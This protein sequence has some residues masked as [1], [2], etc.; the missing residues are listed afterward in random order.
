VFD[1]FKYVTQLFKE[2]N[3]ILKPGGVL[4]INTCT[5]DQLSAVWYNN[6]MPEACE[7]LKARTPEIDVL[8]ELIEQTGFTNFAFTKDNEPLQGENY[9]RYELCFTENYRAGDAIWSLVGDEEYG[10]AMMSMKY[11]LRE[12]RDTFDSIAHSSIEKTG[13]TTQ[14]FCTR[15]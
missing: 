13:H 10:K 4:G 7:M 15:V 1:K 2:F 12:E 14:I 3:R 9:W 11:G 8:K 5:H 6:A